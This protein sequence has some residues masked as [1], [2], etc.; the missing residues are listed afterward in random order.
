MAPEIIQSKPYGKPV[1]YWSIG[2]LTYEMSTGKPPF[3]SDQQIKI[4]EKILSGKYKIPSHLSEDIKDFM[5]CLI[6]PDLTKRYGNLKNGIDDIKT[7]KWFFNI[8]WMAI[9][10]KKVVAPMIPKNK[11]ILESTAYDNFSED[12]IPISKENLFEK[13]F[14]DF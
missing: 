7:H 8:D 14:I 2:I 6:Q 1:D 9:Y 10:Q 12:Q 13:E 4:Y 3:Q 11:Q 5:R